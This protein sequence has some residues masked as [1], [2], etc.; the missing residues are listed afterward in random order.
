MCKISWGSYSIG[1]VHQVG[2]R[3]VWSFSITKSLMCF[4]FYVHSMFRRPFFLGSFKCMS[5]KW[6]SALRN[7]AFT[8]WY[9]F[10]YLK[11]VFQKV[12]KSVRG[13][14]HTRRILIVIFCCPIMAWRS[15]VFN[16]P[17]CCK[18]GKMLH[19]QLI[20]VDFLLWHLDV[21]F[22]L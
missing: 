8:S 19:K 10:L 16:V 11:S 1:F 18:D 17:M 21:N 3:E 7:V 15:Q 13:W 9:L 20:F 4:T 2:K 12:L 6:Y 22:A 14:S 5:G